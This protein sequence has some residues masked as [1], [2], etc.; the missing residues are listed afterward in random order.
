MN[1][2]LVADSQCVMLAERLTSK[3]DT[4]QAPIVISQAEVD[5]PG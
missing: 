4:L 5:V 1:D 2:D 3:Q